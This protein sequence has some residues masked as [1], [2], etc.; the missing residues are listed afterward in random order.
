MGADTSGGRQM[1][2]LA[3]GNRHTPSG[4]LVLTI[5]FLMTGSFWIRFT[6]FLQVSLDFTWFLPLLA[7]W[8]TYKHG[9]GVLRAWWPLAILPSLGLTLDGAIGFRFGVSSAT[10]L[11]SLVIAAAVDGRF[12]MPS[13]R[14]WLRGDTTFPVIVGF[15]LLVVAALDVAQWRMFS[16]P[17]ELRIN[18]LAI[19]AVLILLLAI[20]WEALAGAVWSGLAERTIGALAFLVA[21]LILACQCR[22]KTDTPFRQLPI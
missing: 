15:C 13:P 6:E 5:G 11:L 10:L 3:H 1:S 20:R 12:A 9:I 21:A 16:P 18:L 14:R 19:P 17:S 8:L 22:F 4:R 2:S 7:G